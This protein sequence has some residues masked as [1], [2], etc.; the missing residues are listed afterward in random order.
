MDI[1]EKTTFSYDCISL[2]PPKNFTFKPFPRYTCDTKGKP[3]AD[4]PF[5]APTA[6]DMA[7]FRR[8]SADIPI[9]PGSDMQFPPNQ[10]PTTPFGYST[11][12]KCINCPQ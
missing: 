4:A 1:C 10:G 9:A 7:Q 6:F 8:K 5:I 2:G 3:W 11:R 12:I